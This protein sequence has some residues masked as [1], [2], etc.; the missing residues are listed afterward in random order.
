MA[1]EEN[2]DTGVE[3]SIK[4]KISGLGQKIVGELEEIG[5]SLTGDPLTI[6]EGELNVEVGD[7][8]DDIEHE[9]DE[10]GK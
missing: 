1:Q 2:K 3:H 5:G 10:G 7:I 8:R 6:A 9:G 4:E